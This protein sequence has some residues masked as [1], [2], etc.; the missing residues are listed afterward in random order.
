MA[1]SVMV[2]D[3]RRSSSVR[4]ASSAISHSSAMGTTMAATVRNVVGRLMRSSQ[5]RTGEAVLIEAMTKAAPMAPQMML[6][7]AANL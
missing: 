4:Q 3:L 6:T 1:T 7:M 5:P 2:E